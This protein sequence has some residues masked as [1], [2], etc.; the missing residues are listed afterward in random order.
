MEKEI[1]ATGRMENKNKMYSIMDNKIFS[2]YGQS[3]IFKLWTIKYIQIMQNKNSSHGKLEII[4]KIKFFNDKFHRS[5]VIS[6]AVKWN[7]FMEL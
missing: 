2:N 6:T 1:N 7:E 4:V 5:D 3:N